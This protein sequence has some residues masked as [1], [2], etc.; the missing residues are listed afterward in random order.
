MSF[1]E[2]CWLIVK[3]CAGVV[4]LF[5]CLGFAAKKIAAKREQAEKEDDGHIFPAN[6]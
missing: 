4:A 5:L 6:G 3:I 1:T 2:I